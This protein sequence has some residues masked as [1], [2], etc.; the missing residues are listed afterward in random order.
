MLTAWPSRDNNIHQT[1]LLFPT[2]TMAF[3]ISLIRPF[4]LIYSRQ[5][6]LLP[7]SE[8]FHAS[9]EQHTYATTKCLVSATILVSLRLHSSNSATGSYSDN[10]K[11]FLFNITESAQPRPI[12]NKASFLEINESN[13]CRIPLVLSDC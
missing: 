4:Q 8:G 5:K 10:M 9:H 7:T 2:V 1:N 3:K 6:L 11:R 12:R 13:L